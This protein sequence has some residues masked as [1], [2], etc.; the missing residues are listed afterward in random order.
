V[1]V[2]FVFVGTFSMSSSSYFEDVES[3]W[4]EVASCSSAAPTVASSRFSSCYDGHHPFV[5]HETPHGTSPYMD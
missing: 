1:F 3:S 5:R 2:S 4:E